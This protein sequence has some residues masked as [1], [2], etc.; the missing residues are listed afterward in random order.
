MCR[1]RVEILKV[2]NSV[3]LNISGINL[4]LVTTQLKISIDLVLEPLNELKYI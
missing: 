1:Y 2:S 4:I 3:G